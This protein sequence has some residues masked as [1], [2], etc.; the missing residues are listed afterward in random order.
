MSRASKSRFSATE[1]VAG[2]TRF[3]SVAIA[4]RPSRQNHRASS[5][6]NWPEAI[7]LAQ[8]ADTSLEAND[9]DMDLLKQVDDAKGGN[10]ENGRRVQDAGQGDA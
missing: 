7:G 2:R 6:R 1:T 4:A 5:E 10:H 3:E 9:T 8:Y